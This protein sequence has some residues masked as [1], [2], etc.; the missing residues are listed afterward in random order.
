MNLTAYGVADPAPNAVAANGRANTLCVMKKA[1]SYFTPNRLMHWN[2]MANP[3]C[4]NPTKSI[5]VNDLIKK[6]KKDEVRLIGK[7]S[8]ARRPYADGEVK[9]L[10]ALLEGEG[11]YDCMH[12]FPKNMVRMQ[13]SMIAR[14]DDVS[15]LS[16][17]GLKHHP[18]FDFA[19]SQSVPL[20]EKCDGG[21]ELPTPRF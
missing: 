6:V 8:Q 20:V 19:L 15:M 3:P 4:G 16:L 21:T 18:R 9:M 10:L 12:R 11:S 7:A 17:H 2:A 1:F 5:L 14:S 13:L